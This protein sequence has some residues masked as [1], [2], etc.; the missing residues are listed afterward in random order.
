MYDPVFT[1]QVGLERFVDKVRLKVPDRQKKKKKKIERKL[2]FK[3]E[4]IET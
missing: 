1:I 2:M 3:E 4:I